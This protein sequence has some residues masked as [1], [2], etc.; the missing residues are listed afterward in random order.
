[1]CHSYIKLHTEN[2]SPTIFWGSID[3]HGAAYAE[4]A[5]CAGLRSPLAVKLSVS[6]GKDYLESAAACKRLSDKSA[7]LTTMEAMRWSF[8]TADD[9]DD[10]DDDDEKRS[11]Q[12]RWCLQLLN[13][14]VAGQ[15]NAG[16]VGHSIC[17]AVSDSASNVHMK[18]L[19]V[20]YCV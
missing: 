1:M 20:G 16:K 12:Q 19:L 9:E 5:V 10:D 15:R 11:D 7:G 2:G 4:R 18:V 6:Y 13:F 3:V 17:A 8:A 14:Q